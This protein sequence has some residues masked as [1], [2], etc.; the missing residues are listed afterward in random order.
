MGGLTRR[1]TDGGDGGRVIW[2]RVTIVGAISAGGVIG[3][4]ARYA[5]T[6]AEPAFPWLTLMV[7]VVGCLAIGGLM[8][9]LLELTAPHRLLRPFLSVGVLGGFTTF[10]AYAVGVRELIATDRVLAALGYLFITPPTALMATWL[11]IVV[12]N[13]LI[14]RR[15]KGA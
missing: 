3:A 4:E 10:S 13:A 9:V 12:T 14:R 1:I 7:N 2:R 11:G 6:L 15:R 5:V 8:A